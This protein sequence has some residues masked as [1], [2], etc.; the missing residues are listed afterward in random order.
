MLLLG[1]TAAGCSPFSPIGV[2]ADAIELGDT[3]TSVREKMGGDGRKS[4]LNTTQ[5]ADVMD[6]VW[7]YDEI[8]LKFHINEVVEIRRHDPATG[9]FVRTQPPP[10]QR[11][12]NQS[13]H[14]TPPNGPTTNPNRTVPGLK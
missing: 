9:I 13:T 5:G 7:T 6:F 8:E 3:V 12:P 4:D 10:T 14:P 2:G 11:D 1:L